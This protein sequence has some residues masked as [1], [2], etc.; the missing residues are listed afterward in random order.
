MGVLKKVE[1]ED[2]VQDNKE[3]EPFFMVDLIIDGE[4]IPSGI[5][6]L[7]NH[8]FWQQIGEQAERAK[9]RIKRENP[10]FKKIFSGNFSM[11]T[12]EEQ[13]ELFLAHLRG[14]YPN[15]DIDAVL[16]VFEGEIAKVKPTGPNDDHP[17]PEMKFAVDSQLT[18]EIFISVISKL[19][20]ND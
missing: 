9:F 19:N 20:K 5:E 17:N 1:I 6:P 13:Y 3:I 12:P 15:V 8:D 10:R 7:S 4:K 18:K 11:T 2:R 14:K 16:E